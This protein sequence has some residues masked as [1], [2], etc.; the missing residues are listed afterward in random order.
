MDSRRA[1]K[2]A[3]GLMKGRDVGYERLPSFVFSASWREKKWFH[4]EPPRSQRF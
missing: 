3:K 1:A 4:A 2:V